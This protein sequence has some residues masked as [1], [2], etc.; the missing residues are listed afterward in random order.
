MRFLLVED[1]AEI[2]T[3]VQKMLRREGYVVDVAPELS[4][5]KE[6]MLSVDYPLVIVDRRLPDGEGLSLI[7]FAKRKNKTSRF[8]VISALSELGELVNGL[9]SGA[10]DYIVK[11]F[12]PDELLARIRAALRRP[13]PEVHTLLECGNIHFEEQSR[14]VSI[15]GKGISFSRRELS[16]IEILLRSAGR[17]VTRGSIETAVY[18]F[19]DDIQS[20]TLESH[21]SRVR[22]VLAQEK[23]EAK[24]HAVRGVG[25]MI[26][27]EPQ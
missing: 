12:E 19:D 15:N 13:V 10:D 14:S 26:K 9:D 22:K 4:L 1:E 7:D 16:V 6:A 27:E 21:I 18:G 17:V 3:L 11:P 2:A 5:A 23:A 25:Y 8:L 24:I 20:N